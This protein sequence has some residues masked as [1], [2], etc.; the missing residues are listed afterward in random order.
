MKSASFPAGSKPVT[1][2]EP[3]TLNEDEVLFTEQEVFV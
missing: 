2:D 1:R 3:C